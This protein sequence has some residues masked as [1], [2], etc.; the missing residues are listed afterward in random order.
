[1]KKILLL[2]ISCA[3]LSVFHSCVIDGPSETCGKGNELV[4]VA[5]PTTFESS[6]VNTKALTEEQLAGDEFENGINTLTFLLFD[7]DGKCTAN[8]DILKDGVTTYPIVPDPST[9]QYSYTMITQQSGTV[10][11]CYVANWDVSGINELDELNEAL[12]TFTGEIGVDIPDAGMP[13]LGMMEVDLS[14]PGTVEISLKRLLAKVDL[15]V[16]V[17]LENASIDLSSGY[18]CNVPTKM[19][20]TE[21]A[22]SA[23]IYTETD[24]I[25]VQDLQITPTTVTNDESTEYTISLYLPEYLPSSAST[26]QTS[27]PSDPNKP[28]YPIFVTIEGMMHHPEYASAPVK[29]N[30]YIGGN[31]KSDFQILR[32]TYYNNVL[33]IN[34][35]ENAIDGEDERVVYSGHNL[36]NPNNGTTEEAA[37]CY[38]ISKPGR[39]MFPAVQ[40]AGDPKK[41]T[42]VSGTEYRVVSDGSNAIDNIR[43]VDETGQ[44][45]DA[46]LY[47]AFDYFPSGNTVKDGNSVLIFGDWSW[48]LWFCDDSTRPD[49]KNQLDI[50]PNGEVAMN[51]SLGAITYNGYEVSDEYLGYWSAGSYYQYGRKDPMLL[52]G[53]NLYKTDEDCSYLLSFE[54]PT[55]F[56]KKWTGTLTE[57]DRESG[58]TNMYQGW[59]DG[60]TVNDPCPSGYKVPSVSMWSEV[61]NSDGLETLAS[62]LVDAFPYNLVMS[63]QLNKNIVFPYSSHISPNTE[64][65][66]EVSPYSSEYTF[67]D[68]EFTC[69]APGFNTGK[70]GKVSVGKY[71]ID[72]DLMAEDR[73]SELVMKI[74][75]SYQD[76]YLWATDGCLFYM[77]GKLNIASLTKKEFQDAIDIISYKHE[78]REQI[79]FE[80]KLT[81]NGWLPEITIT[82]EVWSDFEEISPSMSENDRLFVAAQ[83]W[84]QG[85]IL[86]DLKIEIISS[87]DPALGAQVRCV[88]E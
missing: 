80:G 44:P 82:K 13:M 18:I 1:M 40:G 46:G 15:T 22:N 73:F 57:S 48:H 31:N 81:W 34:G 61:N 20:L 32:N 30:I 85:G 29:Y 65:A 6:S 33:K 3:L 76:G 53:S 74:D 77:Y 72:V 16:S 87:Y 35:V 50:Y 4:F 55:T 78:R 12:L 51:R 27:K 36:A 42:N 11:A 23:V 67:D 21:E 52:D 88:K 64:L 68:P 37:N 2:I 26:K 79:S 54:N 41:L 62:Y 56:Y 70:K 14:S 45:N 17:G 58:L 24:F 39:Y 84:E 7:S 8:E 59:T 25:E 60:K 38:I 66:L 43:R 10:T 86:S 19:Y 49:L 69:T 63:S 71:S 47:I 5:C 83:L 28:A 75:L 9:G